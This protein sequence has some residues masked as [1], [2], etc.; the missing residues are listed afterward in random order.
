MVN[1]GHHSVLGLELNRKV[2]DVKDG[3]VLMACL[4]RHV[5]YL[6]GAATG[7]SFVAK[8]VPT[9]T[10]FPTLNKKRGIP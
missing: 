6:P 1:G 8:S 5:L 10:Y 2:A 9:Q 3:V 4:I 7:K